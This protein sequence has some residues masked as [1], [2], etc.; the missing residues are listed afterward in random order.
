ME[1]CNRS[2]ISK[3]NLINHKEDITVKKRIKTKDSIIVENTHEPI[4]AR[5]DFFAVQMAMSN[6]SNKGIKRATPKKHLF[7]DVLIC[8][9]CGK[10]L[11]YIQNHKGY[12]CGTYKKYGKNHCSQHEVKEK[13]LIEILRND[14]NQYAK[15]V[16]KNESYY[17]KIEEKL[18]KQQNEATKLRKQIEL[19][20]DKYKNIKGNLILKYTSGEITKDE[21]DIAVEVL[22]KDM[23]QKELKLMHLNNQDSIEEIKKNIELV[24]KQLTSYCEFEEITREVVSRFVDKIIVHKNKDIEIH[25]KFGDYLK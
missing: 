4:I 19:K 7:S 3:I 22:D 25:Y 2:N 1:I 18:N 21:Y 10:K 12:L 11:W 9:D 8:A 23:Q 15:R 6:R 13:N 20:R 17:K 16:N 5:E 24:K 14:L